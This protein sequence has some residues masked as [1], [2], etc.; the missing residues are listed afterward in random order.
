MSLKLKIGLL[1]L[2]LSVNYQALAYTNEDLQTAYAYLN[3]MRSSAGMSSFSQNA[4]LE[5]AATNHALYI[6]T[7]GVGGHY[8]NQNQY[9]E[10]F[11]GT[12]PSDR[13][14]AAGYSG[15]H[16]GENLST[17]M[18][19]SGTAEPPS[20]SIDD[21]LGAI[22]HRFGFLNFSFA[23][24][25]IGLAQGTYALD[26]R[27]THSALVYNMG[28]QN[29]DLANQI[30]NANPS[31]V[32][33]PPV[34]S[35]DIPPAFYTE[36]PYPLSGIG[37]TDGTPVGYPI[38]VQFNKARYSS[39]SITNFQL[40]RASDNQRI[41]STHLLMQSNDPENHFDGFEYAL[42]PLK[43]LAWGTQYRVLVN[44]STNK[45]SGT[46]DWQFTTRCL[47]IPMLST[48]AQGDTLTI[49]SG[50]QKFAIFI[51]SNE[52][53][54]QS[55]SAYSYNLS[56]VQ[57]ER[58]NLNTLL[59]TT[60]GLDGNSTGS[61]TLSGGSTPHSFKL[62]VSDNASLPAEVCE[63]NNNDNSNSTARLANISTRANLAGGANDAY[64]GFMI[65]GSGTQSVLMRGIAS[66]AGNGVDPNLSLLK[67]TNG[68]W[69]N[70]GQNN[71]WEADNNAAGINSLASNL[72]LPDRNNNDAG[73]LRDL[74]SG[75]Y[76]V[77]L[78]SNANHGLA[79]VGVDALSDSQAKLVNISTRAYISGNANDA[80]A[81]FII[82]GT[83]TLQVLLRGIAAETGNGVDPTISLLKFNN[84][85]WQTLER[86][87]E[88]ENGTQ[89]VAIRGL[90][91]NLQLPDRNANDAALLLNLA[92]G[93]Y[94]LVL[95]SNGAAGLAVVGVDVIY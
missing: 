76:S 3:Q 86:N 5:M 83:G 22:Y 74:S 11:T 1:L 31:I 37:L 9:P 33:W 94:T 55:I 39:S 53:V 95:S 27:Y 43:H 48:A 64:A 65:E 10:N 63:T 66:S 30:Q 58:K 80:Y 49:P 72:R 4:A 50:S 18:D 47:G 92:A 17:H 77:V 91:S 69:Q 68:Q 21:L 59:L 88:W 42:F 29:Y 19:S 15:A 93:T 75:V 46:L 73:M 67:L 8:Q 51:D 41:S 70:L 28:T 62:E 44:Y 14:T 56:S 26:N 90:A 85:Q 79:T 84:G 52:P 25:G 81:G 6:I 32:Q 20:D 54:A 38:S 45:D 36:S 34:D 16:T 40:F 12:S 2:A 60:N 24:A 7:H 35:R 61:I 13:T 78:S 57:I 82:T 89:A 71:E 23:E 87:D